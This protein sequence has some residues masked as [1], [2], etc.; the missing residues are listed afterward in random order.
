[1]IFTERT[2][3][4]VNDSATIN[5]PLILYRGD[6]NIELK[7]TIAES[8]FKFR[9]TDASN[10]IETTDA[11]YAQLVINTPYNSPIFSEVAATKNGA[12]IFVITE[13]MIDE[14][15]EVGAYEIQIRLLDDN[16]QS[17]ASIPPVSNA[18]EIRE[19]IAIEDGSVVD[20]NVVNVAKVNRA[21]TTTSAPL[22]AFDSQGNYIKKT[23]GDGDPI[24]DAALNKM[25]AGIEG[26][27]NKV[28][29]VSSQISAIGTNSNVV[30]PRVY[31]VGNEFSNMTADK[32]EVKMQ[33]AYRQ[34]NNF[35][36]NIKIKFQGSSS[37]AYP[38]K[39]FTI[40][41][42]TDDTYGTKLNKQ[43]KNWGISS[44]KYVLKA[45]WIDRT[46]ARNIISARIWGDIVKTRKTIPPFMQN[47]PNTGAIDGF[48]IK[49]FVNG[50]YQGI[51]TW[52]LAKDD[53]L[54]DFT[55]KTNSFICCGE[56][57]A[58]MFYN[59]NGWTVEYPD[60]T[61]TS[62]TT[63]ISNFVNFINNSTDE[64][65]KA[66]FNQYA[67]LA[68]FIDYYIFAYSNCGLDS[69]GKN[70]ILVSDTGDKLY[71]SAYDLDSTWGL[72]WN[73]ST[74]VDY[75][76]PCPDS[77]QENNSALWKRFEPIFKDEIYNRYVE[78]TGFGM[79]LNPV[80]LIERFEEFNEIIT[81]DLMKEDKEIFTGL[82]TVGSYK[83]IRNFIN[84]RKVYVDECMQKI[85]DGTMH[86]GGQIE[87]INI[88]ESISQLAQGST[89]QLTVSVTPSDVSDY[90]VAWSS[91]NNEVATVSTNGLVTGLEVG[92][93][94]I[95]AKVG[96]KTASITLSIIENKSALTIQ[97]NANTS[98][99]FA[100]DNEIVTGDVTTA[101][102]INTTNLGYGLSNA[103]KD[104]SSIVK[105]E[106]KKYVIGNL[107]KTTD[108]ECIGAGW[109]NLWIRILN[110]TLNGAKVKDWAVNN[111]L[112][113]TF[114][115]AS[116]NKTWADYTLPTNLTWSCESKNNDYYLFN[117]I[118]S[119]TDG[120]D[121]QFNFPSVWYNKDICQAATNYF[122]NTTMSLYKQNW[123]G[124]TRLVLIIEKSKLSANT[125]EALNEYLSNN[126][127]ILKY[128]ADI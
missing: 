54:F 115:L 25:E 83:Q 80:N 50:K 53:Y 116:V 22:E 67:D 38:K 60:V 30:L 17:R 118:Y 89:A 106:G 66:N 11:S 44:N 37:M 13:A 55:D 73:G 128:I 81:D 85:K 113:F 32:N 102:P 45:N 34:N 26:V 104:Y 5:K 88:N 76:Y 74:I 77:Y 110:E 108:E 112:E 12:V 49:L 98:H 101:L 120:T 10:V 21:L 93:A 6:K 100:G 62:W 3:T 103:T 94:T 125:S 48:P 68:S 84:E 8:Q 126:P 20:S 57:N 33:L 61:P 63:L 86:V 4:V 72:F 92:E 29:N 71:A 96:D 39:N 31:L 9:N 18:I 1:M 127:I 95:T 91:N 117:T 64:E 82:P 78:L 14:I 124:H 122:G 19:P 27:N 105:C 79:P 52:N 2:I 119:N 35:D 46:H 16:K 58:G 107:V 59:T 99:L 36:A 75:N 23:W 47:C 42:Y 111:N 41:M 97:I 7:I 24:T 28:A 70:M 109:S 121:V 56:S 15:R 43:F 114:D 65:F 40:K 69:L 123:S 90:T 87:S 51:Y